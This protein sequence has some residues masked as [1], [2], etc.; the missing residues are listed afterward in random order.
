VS[1]SVKLP[2]TFSDSDTG[3]E[4]V[5]FRRRGRIY[6]YLRDAETKRFI[7]RLRYVKVKGLLLFDYPGTEH[8][9]YVDAS[10]VTAIEPEKLLELHESA[11]DTLFWSLGNFIESKFGGVVSKLSEV[12]GIEYGSD[13]FDT[14]EYPS[15]REV[16]VWHHYKF[17][18]KEDERDVEL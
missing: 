15:V 7:R 3:E 9:L 11:Y 6:A 10:F 5:I 17:D 16:I 1:E 13:V 18:Y 12:A 2:L 8:P 14:P 4:I